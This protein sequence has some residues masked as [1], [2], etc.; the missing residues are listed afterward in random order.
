MRFTHLRIQIAF[1]IVMSC[2][3]ASISAYAQTVNVDFESFP[4][5]KGTPKDDLAVS[6]QYKNAYGITLSIDQD[7]NPNTVKD[8]IKPSLEQRG[9]QKKGAQGFFYNKGRLYDTEAAPYQG[10]LGNFFLKFNAKTPAK[11]NLLIELSRPATTV[12]GVLWDID[13]ANAKTYEQWKLTAYA[14]VNN[15]YV[16]IGTFNSPK[17]TP[18]KTATT[19]DGKPY[20][21]TFDSSQLGG[22]SIDAVLI[23]F[24]GSKRN[25]L[26]AGFDKLG[27]VFKQAESAAPVKPQTMAEP[28]PTNTPTETPEIEDASEPTIPTTSD[29]TQEETATPTESSPETG[30]QFS[31]PQPEEIMPNSP[32]VP[33]PGTLLLLSGGLFGLMAMIR[34]KYRK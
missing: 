20:A 25:G 10:Q 15:A 19:Y 11:S 29:A 28:T 9:K 8:R 33:E 31:A 24:A 18:F 27:V 23:A 34:R 6:D 21:W 32:A 3:F 22:K 13:A 4:A 30:Q 7:K 16:P 12:S 14:K 26:D 1:F 2:C 17:G 5:G